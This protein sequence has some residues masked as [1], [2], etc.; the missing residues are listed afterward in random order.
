MAT[1][2]ETW[3]AAVGCQWKQLRLSRSLVLWQS[4]AFFIPDSTHTGSTTATIV[5]NHYAYKS[6]DRMLRQIAASVLKIKKKNLVVSFCEIIGNAIE[7]VSCP[8]VS[9]NNSLQSRHT[10]HTH[11]HTHAESLLVPVSAKTAAAPRWRREGEEGSCAPAALVGLCINSR[12]WSCSL[13]SLPGNCKT[14]KPTAA[15]NTPTQTLALW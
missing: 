3:E 11:T 12:Q 2:T 6:C 8:Q 14:Q 5:R 10:S 4:L 1:K 7:W 9:Q 15:D 13:D